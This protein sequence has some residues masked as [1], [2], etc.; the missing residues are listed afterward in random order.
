MT[1]LII[2]LLENSRFCDNIL[3]D[4]EKIACVGTLS[5]DIDSYTT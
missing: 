2:V 5:W 3:I 1:R 4:K